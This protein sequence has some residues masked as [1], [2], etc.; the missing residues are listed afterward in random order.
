MH[1]A[2]IK[3]SYNKSAMNNLARLLNRPAR[4]R[5]RALD[6]GLQPPYDATVN[7]SCL[8]NRM[9]KRQINH[10]VIQNQYNDAK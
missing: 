6:P 2:M 9:T 1:N 3:W 4:Y 5:I 10:T 8:V 7:I